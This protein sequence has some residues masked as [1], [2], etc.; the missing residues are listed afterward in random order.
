MSKGNK[1]RFRCASLVS[2]GSRCPNWALP[3]R[4]DSHKSGLVEKGFCCYLAC[5]NHNAQQTFVLARGATTFTKMDI[6][7]FFTGNTHI[8][9][10][11][12]SSNCNPVVKDNDKALLNKKMYEER[13]V[14]CC[15][16]LS[17][18]AS[19]SLFFN[20][21]LQLSQHNAQYFFARCVCNMMNVFIEEI[22]PHASSE[23]LRNHGHFLRWCLG[24]LEIVA[25]HRQ[26]S[27]N[28][29]K[30][31]FYLSRCWLP[32]SRARYVYKLACNS[33]SVNDSKDKEELQVNVI[34]YSTTFN[35]TR[36]ALLQSSLVFIED[37]AA[38]YFVTQ[39]NV[40]VVGTMIRTALSYA[41]NLQEMCQQYN[42]RPI[43][44]RVKQAVL[45]ILALVALTYIHYSPTMNEHVIWDIEN[46]QP[47]CWQMGKLHLVLYYVLMAIGNN[48]NKTNYNAEAKKIMVMPSLDMTQANFIL[49]T[50]RGTFWMS[51]LAML[52]KGM[53]R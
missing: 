20:Q 41:R 38:N 14:E 40:N 15:K 48:L 9:N 45:R 27:N 2:D 22:H 26:I 32:T 7:R 10:K 46:M 49:A 34:P 53:A 3:V 31:L 36:D 12:R 42:N 33:L 47:F 51:L 19:W 25:S 44:D 24:V 29:Y 4:P 6:A 50:C 30:G 13:L 28:V 18:D 16:N 5:G 37:V 17:I 11:T 35:T 8:Q 43:S 21:I 39:R 1:F 23:V 52:H